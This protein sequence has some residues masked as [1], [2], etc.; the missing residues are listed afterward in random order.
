M[1]ERALAI[2]ERLVAL[3]RDIH[4]HPELGFRETRTAQLVADTLRELGVRARTGVGKTGVVGYLGEGSPVVALRADMDAL[5]LQ[6]VNQVPYASQVPGVMHACG[7][8]AH[9]AILLGVAMLLRDLQLPGQ[10]RLL[11]QPCEESADKEGKSGAERMIED[12]AMEGV[13]AVLSLHVGSSL[14]TG[15]FE[16]EAG[17]NSAA[18]DTFFA[19]IVGQGCHGAYPQRGTDPIFITAQVI[20]ALNGIVSRRID[21]FQPAVIS[22]GSIH[23]GVAP[24]VIPQQVELNGTIR[25]LSEEVRAQLHSELAR[26]FGVA[27]AL[28]ATHALRI[29]KGVPSVVNDGQVV[30]VMRQVVADLFGADRL[31]PRVQG[32]GAEDFSLLAEAAPGAMFR[33]GTMPGAEERLGHSDT[34]DLDESALAYGAAILAE[35]ARR[36]LTGEAPLP[37]RPAA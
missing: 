29:E 16:V 18:V 20:N 9:T 6:E 8:D 23:A 5:P 27:D 25:S 26:A 13:D 28:G 19:T 34:F 30:A 3:R 21:P 35:T 14:P 22:I 17:T 7:H 2:Q 12:G 11:F 36:F 10:V 4:Q 1:Y 32:M 24:N 15:Y 31:L 37:Q 33:L